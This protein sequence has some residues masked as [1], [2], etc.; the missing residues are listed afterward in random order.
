[1]DN[2]LLIRKFGRIGARLVLTD[3]EKS[4]NRRRFAPSKGGS[5]RIDVQHDCRGE[6]FHMSVRPD[7][8]TLDV[9][10]VQPDRRH[11][12]LL[13]R[14]H[15][16]G[17]KEKYLCGHDERAWFVA[18]VPDKRGVSNVNT[19]MEALKPDMVLHEQER[20]GLKHRHRQR[21]R[22]KAFVRQGEWFFV[23]RPDFVPKNLIIQHEPL[24]RGIGSKPHVCE[25]MAR[26]AGKQVYVCRQFPSGLSLK[27]YREYIHAHPEATNWNWSVRMRDARVY[28]CGTVRH[29]DHKTIRLDGWHQVAMNTESE[30]RAMRHIVF[31]D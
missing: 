21:R 29:P 30:S 17:S 18:A 15:D 14:M 19:A 10:D 28:V 2:E 12:L 23:P 1:M 13:G 31:L 3:S 6:Y 9:I 27:R 5:L 11:L 26:E 7:R 25:Y 22:T 24:S 16:D 4:R 20:V 8:V